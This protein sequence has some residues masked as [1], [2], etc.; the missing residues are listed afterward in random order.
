MDYTVLKLET[1]Q[2]LYSFLKEKIKK[3]NFKLK[4]VFK[5]N[6]KSIFSTERLF[7]QSEP[8]QVQKLSI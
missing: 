7:F 6:L 3:Y 1:V 5:L 4:P 8:K 2:F